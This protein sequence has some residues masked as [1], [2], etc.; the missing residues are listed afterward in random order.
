M[1][2]LKT[3][4]GRSSFKY[5]GSVAK[6]TNILY[7]SNFK[8]TTEISS[9]QYEKLFDNFRGKTVSIGTSRTSPPIGSLGEWLQQNVNRT[10][11]ASYIGAILVSERYAIKNGDEIK[12][13]G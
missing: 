9:D 13:L 11:L 12:I 1:K 8:F 6:G 3:W 10:A 5:D 2:E 4:A 7:G